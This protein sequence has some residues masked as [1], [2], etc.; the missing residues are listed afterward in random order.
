M[1]ISQRQIEA[2]RLVFQTGS[3]TTAAQMM[4]V[5][6]PAVS[7]LIRDLEATLELSLFV[8]SGT[9]INTTTDA[10][11]FFSEVERSFVGLQQLEHT[12]LAIRQKR[13]GF[14]HVATTGAFGVLCLPRAMASAR[15]QSPKLRIRLTVTRSAEIL[16]LVATRRCHL[17]ITAIPPNTAGIEY[18]DLP[19]VPIVCVLPPGHHLGARKV[20]HPRDL[21]GEVLYGP[22]ENTRLHQQIAHAFAQESVPFDLTGDCTLGA[23]ICEFV[24]IGAGVAVLDALAARGAGE[25]R[26]IIRPFAPRIEWE[27]KLL[28]PAGYPRAHQLTLLTRSI[29]DWLSEIITSAPRS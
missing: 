15:E 6:Q 11:A 25:T 22:P 21:A 13:E 12:A 26:V 28:F 14:L 20:L 24:A 3:M 16:D 18:D 1:R 4:G 19:S 9:G 17:G 10:I 7:R 23:S 8:R 27:P 29:R 5:T 2:F